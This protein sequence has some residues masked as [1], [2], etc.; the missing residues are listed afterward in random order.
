MPERHWHWTH[1]TRPSKRIGDSKG[2]ASSA[3][4][5]EPRVW[6]GQK[7]PG[8][9]SEQEKETS[10]LSVCFRHSIEDFFWLFFSFLLILEI[11]KSKKVRDRY[12]SRGDVQRLR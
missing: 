12:R 6:P 1:A 11:P 8:R 3:I 10:W 2:E 7:R 4:E 5:D 9:I